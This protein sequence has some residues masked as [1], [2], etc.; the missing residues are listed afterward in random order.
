MEDCREFSNFIN[1]MKHTMTNRG[2]GILYQHYNLIGRG[3][4]VSKRCLKSITDI[5]ISNIECKEDKCILGNLIQLS[6]LNNKYIIDSYIKY[7]PF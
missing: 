5:D 7:E 1:T 6:K 3:F 2:A 4:Y